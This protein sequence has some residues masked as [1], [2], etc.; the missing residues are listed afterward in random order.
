MIQA[1]NPKISVIVAV[2]NIEDY[3]ERSVASICG[4]TYKNL[5]ILLVDDGSTDSSGRLCDLLSERDGRIRVIHKKNGG[6][7]DARNAGMEQ[8][9][10]DY[11]GFVDGDDY[12]EPEMY[13]AMLEEMI[14]HKAQVAV[15]SY[16]QIGEGADPC[17]AAGQTIPLSREEALE[18]YL[19]GHESYRIYN[20]VWS[21]LFERELI[22]GFRFPVGKKSEDIMFT[23]RAFC[24]AKRLVYL[25]V[26]Y[27][28]YVIDRAGS[29][30]NETAGKRRFEDEIPF[31]RE[32]AAYLEEQGLTD[33][34]EKSRYHFYRRM[35]FY[36]VE[37]MESGQ[38]Q[39]GKRLIDML[40]QDK[41]VIGR[42]YEECG[43][44]KG[45]RVRIRLALFSPA[46][47]Y[48]AVRMYD[49]IVIPMRSRKV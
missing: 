10:G 37:F 22:R 48:V 13:Q 40:R 30:M 38:K 26:P 20:S 46:L 3:L 21:K 15:C 14:K 34:A 39:Y 36:F 28:N 7:S 16:N 29:I 33:F 47:Y 6:L 49:K 27:Y 11:V 9:T 4:Q 32:Q 18:L 44:P 8:I 42:V 12:I 5:E 19:C 31:W 24:K 17:R 35:L 1:E 25:D 41:A 23:T 43:A 45:D 2:Y